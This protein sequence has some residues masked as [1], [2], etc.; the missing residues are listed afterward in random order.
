[1]DEVDADGKIL[2]VKAT[3]NGRLANTYLHIKDGISFSHF[4]H[5]HAPQ[6]EKRVAFSENLS[7]G[8]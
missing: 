5:I 7:P 6:L 1:L 4:I 2:A 8:L 3:T